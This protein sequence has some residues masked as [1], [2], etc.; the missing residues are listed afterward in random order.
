V[1]FGFVPG[2][3]HLWK[4]LELIGQHILIESGELNPVWQTIMAK[5]A[6]TGQ[7]SFIKCIVSS[8]EV[9]KL[10]IEQKDCFIA[11]ICIASVNG[12]QPHRI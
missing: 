9:S 4:Y 11:F 6:E 7:I 8:L 12:H 10:T 1:E 5:A 3:A 2:I